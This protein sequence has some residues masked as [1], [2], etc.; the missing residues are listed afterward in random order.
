M[1][2]YLSFPHSKLEF[3]NLLLLLFILLFLLSFYKKSA[4]CFF[5]F[6]NLHTIRTGIFSLHW[7]K[8][9][10][11]CLGDVIQGYLAM[12]WLNGSHHQTWLILS[13]LLFYFKNP[14]NAD[15]IFYFDSSFIVSM[16]VK[17]EY[18]CFNSMRDVA[19]L[20]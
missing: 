1:H 10:T 13:C 18:L 15:Q 6:F 11:N 17:N 20:M 4:L 19:F 2:K 16:Q 5:F 9:G 12:K 3:L 8:W 7:I 14:S